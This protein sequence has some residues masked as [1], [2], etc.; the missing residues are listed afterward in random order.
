MTKVNDK[1][2][3]E[4]ILAGREAEQRLNDTHLNQKFDMLIERWMRAIITATPSQR[5]EVFEAKRQIDAVM[6]VR[7]A[8]KIEFEDGLL[9]INEQEEDDES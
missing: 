7:K 5:D 9:A 3:S 6:D 8:L 2:L 1:T 4:R